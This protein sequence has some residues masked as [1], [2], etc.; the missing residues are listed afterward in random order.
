MLVHPQGTYTITNNYALNQYGQ[1]GLAV[2]TEPLYQA[3]DVVLPGA[4]AAA[5]EA[6]NLTKY[7][8]LDDGSSWNYLT[9]T[10]AKNSPL[11]GG[12]AK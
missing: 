9:N 8:T 7:I 1:L 2:G 12:R 6:A 10:A 11:P 5:Y 4:D 3:T